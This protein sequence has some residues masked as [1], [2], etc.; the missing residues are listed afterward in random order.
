MQLDFFNAT[1]IQ[2][3]FRATVYP[4]GKLGFSRVAERELNLK[5]V[6]SVLI[7]RGKDYEADKVLYLVI[8][9]KNE[10]SAFKVRKSGVYFYAFT[11]HLFRLLNEDFQKS[12]IVYD[13]QPEVLDGQQVFKLKP[14][15]IERKTKA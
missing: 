3:G 12:K 4:T 11:K 14:R 7:G 1:E 15:T 10:P 9:T 8:D 2:Q 6:T 13:I 5:D